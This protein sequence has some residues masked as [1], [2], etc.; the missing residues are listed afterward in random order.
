MKRFFTLAIT[1]VLLVSFSLTSFASV[2]ITHIY[3]GKSLVEGD[4]NEYIFTFAKYDDEGEAS[5]FGVKINGESYSLLKE[6]ADNTEIINT[7]NAK[8]AFGI[9]ICDPENALTDKYEVKPYIVIDGVEIEGESTW[10]YKPFLYEKME[11]TGGFDGTY[12]ITDDTNSRTNK[13]GDWYTP[14]G[15]YMQTNIYNG[16]DLGY[17]EGLS[18]GLIQVD[19]SKLEGVDPTQPV[20]LS[21]VGRAQYNKTM[22]S[23]NLPD[24]MTVNA[25]GFYG[26][27]WQTSMADYD[28]ESEEIP[29]PVYS[30]S[31]D[32]V[33]PNAGYIGPRLEELYEMDLLDSFTVLRP[34]EDETGTLSG[35]DVVGNEWISYEIDIK[36]IVASA[37][38]AG[39]DKVTIAILADNRDRV[40]YS[41]GGEGHPERDEIILIMGSKENT[42]ASRR[43]TL[44]YYK[45]NDEYSQLSTIKVNGKEISGFDSAKYSYEVSYDK[46]T[47]IPEITAECINE[48]SRAV[49]TQATEADKTAT[50]VVYDEQ[51]IRSKTY[52]VNFIAGLPSTEVTTKEAISADAHSKPGDWSPNYYPNNTVTNSDGN[53][54][55]MYMA[56]NIYNGAD[57]GSNALTRALIEVDITK[58]EDVDLNKEVKL[59]VVGMTTFIKLVDTSLKEIT[60]DAYAAYNY[61]LDEAEIAKDKDSTVN[62]GPS[63]R[64]IRAMDKLGSF[65]VAAPT[66]ANGNPWLPYSVDI[67]E[68]IK[69]AKANNKTNV[70]IILFADNTLREDKTAADRDDIILRMGTK[71]NTTESRQPSVTYWQ[72]NDENTDLTEIQIGG[73][74]LADF[75]ADVFEYDVYYDYGADI[76]N[77]SATAYDSDAKVEI[78]DATEENPVATITVTNGDM[79]AK[80]YTVNFIENLP[81][82]MVTT[83]EAIS[84][85]AHSKPGDWSPNYYPNNTVT[86]SDGKTGGIYMA[87][88]IYNG[89]DEGSNALTRALIEVDITKL[90]NVDLTKEVKLNVVGMTTFNKLVDT[91][92]KEITV[93]AYAAYNYDL[94]EAEIAKNKDSTVNIGP[95][96]RE[97]RA[98]D[99]LGSFTV[100]APTAASGNPWVPYS[101]DIKEAIKTAKANNKTNVTIILFADNTLREDKT[102]ADRDDII[103]RMGTKENTT[104]SRQPSVTYWQYNDE[105]TDLTEIKID[106]EAL[107]GFDADVFNYTAIYVKGETIPAV[108]ATAFHKAAKVEITQATVENPVATIKVTNESLPAKTYTVTFNTIL[109]SKEETV[110]AA[111]TDDA[112]SNPK[113]SP[114]YLPTADYMVTNIYYGATNGSANALMRAMIK[115]DVAKLTDIDTSKPVYLNVT[116]QPSYNYLTD[117]A[118]NIGNITVNAYADYTNDIVESKIDVTAGSI[119]PNVLATS[120]LDVLDSFTYSVP[121]TKNDDPYVTKNIDITEA[122]KT[123][124]ANIK[125]DAQAKTTVLIIL[126]ADNTP[127]ETRDNGGNGHPNRNDI[128]FRMLTKDNT[129]NVDAVPSVTY[130][131]Y[132]DPEI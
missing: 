43:P 48:E 41:P 33:N 50:I 128:M 40:Q 132:Y 53:T 46:G 91:S 66:A 69:T 14:T 52:T 130:Y 113:A 86:N 83:K 103:L 108:S 51:N 62:I 76:P 81:S 45:Y 80:T 99:K 30:W 85:D 78:T 27:D 61:D 116:G 1:L 105:N 59:N 120:R 58:L 63:I 20:T 68:A 24:S 72:Y 94:D 121:E 67:K 124:Q 114:N 89:A 93:D 55:G 16:A 49:I 131:K 73:E 97:I 90:E 19:L 74:S 21:V 84:A 25:F 87:T 18:R 11:S 7:T 111:I 82:T 107:A 38:R 54:G 4:N 100:A 65:T 123:V 92:L 101:V 71:E 112:N 10:I 36:D 39:E 32:T 64:E 60:V 35:N 3:K 56:T 88:N 104:E 125:A 34:I 75:D 119:D 122:I 8:K 26:Y 110:T 6:G 12:A 15:I 44:S 17:N 106:G 102:V 96:I 98:M 28:P 79:D 42:T 70:T 95:S 2:A 57:E 47:D 22:T 9:G 37:I 117:T 23:E 118:E 31:E 115:I 129:I 13:F 77:V 109:P 126:M 127:Y 5:D 29:V